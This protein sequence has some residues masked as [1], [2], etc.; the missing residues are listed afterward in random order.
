VA[1]L[2]LRVDHRRRARGHPARPGQR[3][4]LFITDRLPG[5]DNGNGIRI[6]NIIDGLVRIG[7]VHVCLIDSTV[8]GVRPPADRRLTANVVRAREWRRWRKVAGSLGPRP[9]SVRYRRERALHDELTT[10]HGQSWM[11]WD[12]VWCSRARVHMLTRT[13]IPGPR[14]VDLD[15]LNDRLLRSEISDRR[16]QAGWLATAPRNLVDAVQARRWQRLQRDIAAEVDRVVVCSAL[17]QR[18][19]DVPNA[20]VVPNGYPVPAVVPR[21]SDG[22]GRPPS[23]L[24]VGPLTYEPNRLAVQWIAERVLPLVR[25]EVPDFAFDVVGNDL[26]SAAIGMTAPGVRRHGYV[27]DVGPYYAGATVAVTPLHSGGGTR[28]KVIEA[29]ARRVPLVSTS[30]AF[31]GLGLAAERD[32]LV[33]DD[34]ESFAAACVAVARQPGLRSRLTDA[35]Y[36]RFQHHL[37]AEASSH[38]VQRLANDVIVAA[39]EA[40]APPDRRQA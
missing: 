12:L 1:D 2:S 39:A 34:P 14:I 8:E 25:R 23:M 16:L 29:L 19:L 3:R 10:L 30:F 35:G 33:A 18:Y 31:E 32:L 40:G 26:G 21:P 24:F 4:I 7:A 20:A 28:L 15:D 5:T 38:A 36:R 9:P 27:E 6:A 37:T 22:D 11:P 17:D 13:V